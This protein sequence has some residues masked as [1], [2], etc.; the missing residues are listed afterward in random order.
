MS[1]LYKNS[2]LYLFAQLSIKAASFLLLPLY[3]RLITPEEYGNIYLLITIS[4]FLTVLFSITI[5][6]SISRFYFDCEDKKDVREMYS[7]IIKFI[8]LFSTTLYIITILLSNQIFFFLKIDFF[9]YAFLAI[10]SSY[11]VIFYN[12]IASLLQASQQAKKLSL[13]TIISSITTLLLTVF[14]VIFMEDKIY[15]YLLS[16]FLGSMVRFLIF[17]IFSYKYFSFKSKDKKLKKYIKYSGTRLP[18]DLSSWIVTFADRLMLYDLKGA[19]DSG[20]YSVGYT[21]GQG[22]EVLFQSINKA[23][24]PYSFD[25]F[26]K[27][28]T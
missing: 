9:P 14:L 17:L 19:G 24:V 21:I 16:F 23:Y 5:Q 22:I 1:N 10:L 26:K 25:H 18:V 8:F 4:N 28:E 13:I 11:L 2:A 7:S 27:K 20:I 15:A 12:L 3:T 6:S